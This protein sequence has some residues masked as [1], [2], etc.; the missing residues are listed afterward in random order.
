MFDY[1][2][3]PATRQTTTIG[4]IA[5][6]E[7]LQG[8][9]YPSPFFDVAHTYLPTTIKQMF[10][11]CRY[12][13][14]TNPLIAATVNKMAEYP[15]TD[16]MID[17]DNAG[18]KEKWSDFFEDTIQLRPCMIESGLF[19]MTFGNALISISHPFVKWLSCRSCGPKVQ[20][21][22]AKFQFR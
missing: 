9:N 15:I 20:A 3:A 6:G 10:R 21:K 17:E 11:W 13:Y 14:L 4:R 16:I 12:Y 19:Y 5:G 1:N 2:R 8:V 22:K 18:L 7:R